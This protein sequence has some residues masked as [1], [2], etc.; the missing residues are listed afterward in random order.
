MKLILFLLV[1]A[2]L[3]SSCASQ[4]VYHRFWRGSKLKSLSEKDFS[5]QLKDTFIPLTEKMGEENGAMVAYQPVI[6]SSLGPSLTGT[7][8]KLFPDEIALVTYKSRDA[9]TKIR[10]TPEGM[11]YSEQHWNYFDRTKSASVVVQ[12]NQNLETFPTDFPGFGE[13]YDIFPLYSDWRRNRSLLVVHLRNKKT[14]DLDYRAE[15]RDYLRR[16]KEED[17]SSGVVGHVILVD[18]TY[19]LE[20]RSY[21]E[22]DVLPDADAVHFNTSQLVY[23]GVVRVL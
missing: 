6:T 21:R 12:P 11:S 17:S 7:L 8:P 9:Y 14:S 1:I 22:S 18:A 13:A 15:M 20:F 10:S 23:V 4:P 16:A 3:N 5:S 2:I 19:W